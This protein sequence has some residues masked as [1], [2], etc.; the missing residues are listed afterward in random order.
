MVVVHARKA[1]GKAAEKRAQVTVHTL[2]LYLPFS[3]L[4]FS[5][6]GLLVLKLHVLQA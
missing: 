4:D 2:Y 1:A 5:S 6:L 3:D